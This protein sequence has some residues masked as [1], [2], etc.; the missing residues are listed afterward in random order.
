[1]SHEAWHAINKLS[2]ILETLTENN[3]SLQV[4]GLMSSKNGPLTDIELQLKKYCEANKPF[5]S[6]SYNNSNDSRLR[7]QPSKAMKV[8]PDSLEIN[9]DVP[10]LGSQKQFSAHEIEVKHY[11]ENAFMDKLHQYKTKESMLLHVYY[12]RFKNGLWY[13]LKFEIRLS[14]EQS[15]QYCLL[16]TIGNYD[17]PD[18][19]GLTRNLQQFNT[20]DELVSGEG[21]L[22]NYEN[23]RNAVI[24]AIGTIKL[25]RMEE[26]WVHGTKSI[27][28]DTM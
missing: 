7:I 10:E 23:F 22:S 20:L 21:C 27:L 4:G 13:K 1:M 24:L 2:S 17:Y 5:F 19:S 9:T 18:T 6:V 25:M 11:Q 3:G 26:A 14:K 8:W 15:Y 12:T 16:I 28:L